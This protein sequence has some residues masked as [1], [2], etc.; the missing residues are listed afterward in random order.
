MTQTESAGVITA[1]ELAIFC[2]QVGAMLAAGVDLLQAI[3]IASDQSASQRLKTVARQ[4]RTDLENGRLLAT[5]LTRY[6]DL[7]SP[8]FVSMVRQG[9][10]EGVLAQVMASMADYLDRERGAGSGPATTPAGAAA[11]DLGEVIERLKPLVFW[12]MLTLGIISLGIAGLWWASMWGALPPPSFGPNI[13]LWVGV[14]ILV[15]ALIFRKFRPVRIAH[16]SFCGRPESVT[17]A[18]V[19]GP[20]VAICSACLRSN[21]EQMK[22][23]SRQEE[24]NA[25]LQAAEE[26]LEARAAQSSSPLTTRNGTGPSAIGDEPSD[27][28]EVNRIEI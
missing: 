12:Q 19:Q 17:G 15:S 6:P 28:G 8:F 4:L 22:R 24:E 27:E 25:A 2:R 16:C 5:A 13:A 26:Q 21:V 1:S 10:R 20:G 18:L 7:F 9:E 23:V 3:Q 14:C 11:L